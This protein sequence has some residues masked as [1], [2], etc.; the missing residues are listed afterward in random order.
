MN[1]LKLTLALMALLPT[2]A[3][4]E[5]TPAQALSTFLDGISK[6]DRTTVSRVLAA[7]VQIYESGYVER[8]RDEYLSHHF[9][10]D[11]QFAKSVKTSVLKRNEMRAGDTAIIWSETLTE[12]TYKGKPVKLFGT[13]TVVLKQAGAEWQIIHLHWS[14]RK[15]G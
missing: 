3:L 1:R 6:A 7:D 5:T 11:A 4:A 15:P 12:G 9:A 13:E 8:S 14:S 2:P 10:A